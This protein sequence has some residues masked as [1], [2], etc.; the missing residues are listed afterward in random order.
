MRRITIRRPAKRLLG[1][2]DGLARVGA[3]DAVGGACVVVLGTQQVLQLDPFGA[4]QWQVIFR[5]CTADQACTIE[6][7]G[8]QAHTQGIGRRVV[9]LENRTEVVEH[10][11]GRAAVTGRQQQCS[12]Q[13][14]RACR[15]LAAV[16]QR[17]AQLAPF[18][19][20]LAN[21]AIGQ[22]VV[23][24][25][26]QLDFKAPWLTSLPTGA[27]QVM[28][29]RGQGISRTAP[30]IAATI[31]VEI[32]GVGVVGGR[33]KLGLAHRTGPGAQHLLGFDVALLQDLQGG[34]QL[35]MGEARA[36]AFIGQGC[37]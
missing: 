24:T 6:P 30:D 25:V 8:Q 37:Q 27:L 15:D 23:E 36:A 20:T 12:G 9:V 34:D 29:G 16:G 17:N 33:D 7:F 32:H 3:N 4:A 11:E 22:H 18:G 28:R 2:A 21:R 5:P 14:L 1:A 35:R 10:Q 13:L 26:R 31:A 19:D